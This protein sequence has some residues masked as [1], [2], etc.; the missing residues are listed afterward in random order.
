MAKGAITVKIDG[1]YDNKDINRA[2][3]DLESLKVQAGGTGSGMDVLKKGFLAVG[4]A[5]AGMATIGAVTS[6]LENSMAAAME[7]E[8]SMVAL[9]KAMD[10]VGAGSANTQ[11]EDFIRSLMLATGVADD[12]LRPAFQKLVTA[13]GDVALSQGLLQTAM[14]VSAGT[15]RDLASVSQALAKASTGQLSALTRLGVPLDANIVKTKDF[16]AA[17][18]VLNQKFGGQTEAAVGTFAGQLRLV[19]T[20]AGEASETVGYALLQ[21][22]QNVANVFGG[23]GG[24]SEA[25]TAAGDGLANFVGGVGQAI[26]SMAEMGKATTD[27]LNSETG[28]DMSLGD[29]LMTTLK[30]TPGI[31]LLVTTTE[32]LINSGADATAEAERLT[33]ATDAQSARM[34]AL[35]A[36][37]SPTAV[38]T[39]EL[40]DAE[41]DAKQAADD[42]T[43]S[44]KRFESVISASQ[45]RDDFKKSLADLDVTLKGNAR[46]F[47][48]MGDAAKENRD[49][50]RDSLSD[51]ARIAKQWG[52]D[53]GA[54][55]DEIDAK[56][57]TM[58]KSIIQG[59]R[60]AG[61]KSEDI[62]TFMGKEGLWRTP[63]KDVV[64]AAADAASA[65]AR[66]S[67]AIVGKD[68]AL[69]AAAG[70]R[71]NAREVANEAIRM[72]Q[73]AEIAARAESETHSPSK[74]WARVG[75]DIVDG[76]VV[77]LRSKDDKVKQAATDMMQALSDKAGEMVAKWDDRLSTLSDRL[78]KAKDEM[79]Q[80]A[81]SVS[82]SIM[83]ALNFGSANDLTTV[84][85]D[86]KAIGMSF[87]DGLKAQAAQAVEFAKQV[88]TLIQMG[89]SRESLQQVLAAGV[90]AGSAI[91]TELI[92]GGATAITET[93]SLVS[94][95]QDAATK[96]GE[97][98]GTTFFGTGVGLA[99]SAYDGFA[100]NFGKGGPARVAME[101][102]MDRLAD[103]LHREVTVTVRTVYEAA[104]NPPGRAVGGPVA[105]GMPYVVGE[106]G[107]E[108]FVPS[109]NGTIIP[110]NASLSGGAP[111]MVGGSAGGNTYA[112]TVQAG[113]GD[114]RQIG[115][116]VVEYIK[117]Y[118]AA[119]GPVYAAA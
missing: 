102:L 19:Q 62:K 21:S 76:L 99:Q 20:A 58:R 27:W 93:N 16:G 37:L 82:S 57:K 91:A 63:A 25:L 118:E 103:S 112:I 23:A 1:Q 3:K 92:D 97:L 15:G 22:A 59:F 89:L 31:G 86:G 61:F 11:V 83:S 48:G 55:A 28:L 71:A 67:F 117:R 60:D 81:T 42:L 115:Q 33:R 77:G 108:L 38:K 78:T 105:S 43:A 34:T 4:A 46:S 41:A 9:A 8:K 75:S 88:T 95:T 26:T 6:F 49:T 40:A 107:P 65:N 84:G 45:A 53:T 18:D 68:I 79:A 32:G 106:R 85:E 47:K 54:S 69:G 17:I 90:T 2:I 24:V 70:I 74:V 52:T 56:Y 36:S 111:A 5:A 14:D 87:L 30:L 50:L 119:N 96:V 80:F 12:Q 51:A 73:L 66:P 72:V 35:A 109:S 94:S 44:I 29:L 39:K 104:G 7:D 113:V 13:T 114:P 116:Q 100:A 64:Q 101:N 110:N 98:A 10:N